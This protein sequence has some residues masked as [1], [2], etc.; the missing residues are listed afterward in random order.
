MRRLIFAASLLLVLVVSLAAR[1]ERITL[2]SPETVPNVLTYRVDQFGYQMDDPST[3]V[4]EGVLHIRLIG[5]ERPVPNTCTY[6]AA[7]TPTATFL[8]TALQKANLSTAYAGNATTGS[9]TQRIFHRLVVMG[10]ASQ[11]CDR[12]IA[13]ILTG[14]PQ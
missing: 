13:G 11:V 10:E 14:S 3:A 2:S 4:D 12:P 7:T 9:L 1:Q 5:V 8:I 6:N